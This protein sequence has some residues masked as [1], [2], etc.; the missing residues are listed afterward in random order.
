MQRTLY[1]YMHKTI[2]LFIDENPIS[3]VL[4]KDVDNEVKSK[5]QCYID[6]SKQTTCVMLASMSF[7]PY[8]QYK[9]IDALI[10]IMHFKQLFDGINR[11]KRQEISMEFLS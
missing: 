4:Y 3:F 9:N 2:V 10:I 8:T 1:F 6:D 5:Y 7:E 11:T